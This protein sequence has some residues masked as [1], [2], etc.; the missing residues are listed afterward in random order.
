[1]I[2]TR[3][4]DVLLRAMGG[5]SVMLRMPAP[6]VPSD[7]AEQLG[8]A[9]PGFQDLPLSPVVF[10]KARAAVVAG[11]TTKWELLV[12]ATAVENIVGSLSYAAASVL[13]AQAFGILC[14]D[15]LLQIISATD[16][17]ANGQPYLYRL[18]L[19]ASQGQTV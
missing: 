14:D 19:R 17:Q 1:M 9:T 13:F 5:R 6:A 11:K 8:L 10:R 2:A 4:A 7:A 3:A 16:E 12:S 18:I 15:G